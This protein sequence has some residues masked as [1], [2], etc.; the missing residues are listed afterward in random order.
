[1]NLKR[2]H[3]QKSLHAFLSVVV[4]ASLLL[5]LAPRV[6]VRAEETAH[7]SDTIDQ[8]LASGDY[9][10]G[11]AVVALL[12]NEDD[13]LQVQAGL[14]VDDLEPLMEVSARA[15]G[16]PSASG[17]SPQGQQRV[18][19]T[20]V[21]SDT[22]ST[23]EILYSL[24]DNPRVAF[25]EP[26]YY[27]EL[28]DEEQ[29][30]FD[31]GEVTAEPADDLEPAYDLEPADDPVE[32]PVT[33]AD[34]SEATAEPTTDLVEDPVTLAE[35]PALAIVAQASGATGDLT[36]LQWG[37][38]DT[39]NRGIKLLDSSVN[40]SINV[41]N[42]GA[43]EVGANMDEEV[44]VAVLDGPV[45]FDNPDLAERAYTF[46]PAMQEQLGCDLHGYNASAEFPDGKI[47]HHL[48]FGTDSHGT[49]CA[50]IIGATWDGKGVSGVAS[51]VRIVSIQMMDTLTQEVNGRT[52]LANGLRAFGFVKRANEAGVGIKVTSNSWGFYQV[53]KALDAAVYEL[54]ESQGVVSVFAAFNDS[55]DNDVYPTSTS[56][57]ADN[58]YA[59]VVAASDQF[60]KLAS[61]SNY[62][63]NTVTLV[64][65]G[66][67][68]LS[69]DTTGRNIYLPAATPDSNILS[70]NF[71]G[72]TPIVTIQQFDSAGN[73]VGE[74]GTTCTETHFVG[75]QSL[76][77]PIDG[78]NVLSNESE[79]GWNI[80]E[81]QGIRLDFDL[82]EAERQTG[83]NVVE[84]LKQ[85]ENLY[86]GFAL[87]TAQQ[88]EV[89]TIGYV[90]TNMTGDAQISVPSSTSTPSKG[91]MVNV[92][93]PLT[94]DDVT[95]DYDHLGGHLIIDI[96]L[97]ADEEC[98]DLYF[99][100]VGIGTQT[101]PYAYKSGTSMACPCI[102]GATAVLASQSGLD[103]AE[104]ASLVRSKVRIPN[105]GPMPVRTGGVFDFNVQG[106]PDSGEET[107][108]A[109]AI[110]SLDVSGTTVTI[111]GSNFG[112]KP[113]L[114]SLARYV[115]GRE[116]NAVG[117]K[118]ASWS[119]SSVV[120]TLDAPF[121]GIMHA[122]L[123]SASGKFDNAS[124]FVS[125]GETVY[126]QDLP[127]DSD[128]GEPFVFNT[129]EPFNGFGDYETKGTLV[130]L[131]CK[132]YYLPADQRTEQSP[133]YQHMFCFDL[134]TETWSEL[135]ALP[136]M[137]QGISAVMYEGKLVVEGATSYTLPSGE[138]SIETD[139]FTQEERV[140]VYDPTARTWSQAPS[141]G[142]AFGET[143][144]NDG[145]Q[146]K[147]VGG[148]VLDEGGVAL[149]P[150]YAYDLSTGLGE[151]ICDPFGVVT[152]PQA[153]AKDGV[154]YLY[155]P[156]A[157]W[158]VVVRDGKATL[159]EDPVPEFVAID[160]QEFPVMSE[161]TR[162]DP[163]VGWG[164]LSVATDGII[165]VGPPAADGSSDT[166]ILNE[167]TMKFEPYA[168]RATDARA[169]SVASCTYR[170]RLFTIGSSWVE[171]GQRFFRATKMD[172]PEYPGD[173]PCE[174]DEPAP[175]PTPAPTPKPT[176]ASTPSRTSAA[177]ATSSRALPKTADLAIPMPVLFGIGAC[178]AAAIAVGSVFRR[179]DSKG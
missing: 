173:I 71:E 15:A 51:N 1:M 22:L 60:D 172:V 80:F 42:F 48:T 131:G 46:S 151:K 6:P 92:S 138:G 10:E 45:D 107:A 111:T 147:L 86:L 25:A 178:G 90:K 28:S 95:Y 47:N 123:T 19:L 74:P 78:S 31:G 156:R 41:P 119:D 11:Q 179:K 102:S 72:G 130:G 77:V 82:A 143:I 3:W 9:A 174:K 105:A 99:D 118:V 33:P 37:N 44:I 79:S 108:L 141:Q 63:V 34:D 84:S 170:G 167:T 142:M 2:S 75:A 7:W 133:V 65:P 59:I 8:M 52:S 50:G 49:H 88:Y 98:P 43:T 154:I 166:Y 97:S 12:G 168:M 106:S 164:V 137:L 68:I 96:A 169:Q 21:T 134:K 153:V 129:G 116:E 126:E 110:L 132:L 69:T 149:A 57:S 76:K 177:T 162:E 155:N 109:P 36:P 61:F 113:G 171:P 104:L 56:V 62:G 100:E 26:N 150:Y 17:L 53:S 101:A 117:Y 87:T 160:K 40:A 18:T 89:Y 144:V 54:G 32:D 165:L 55:R 161:N 20:L 121:T 30:T 5:A 120:L 67:S 135:P 122:V 158:L 14:S 13:Q 85:A 27:A 58:P 16:V 127:F 91:S 140:Y 39:A 115:V 23:E 176:P 70:E 148:L 146:L 114:V 35:D 145:G 29:Y 139:D 73:L 125:K 175:Q 64:A 66:K 93:I 112:S 159:Y 157:Y 128:T 81:Y 24:A 4:S 152:N 163:F 136:E 83:I 103:G 94:D 38:W 124:T